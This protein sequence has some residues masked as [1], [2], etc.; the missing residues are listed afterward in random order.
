M[1]SISNAPGFDRT[2]SNACVPIDPVDP[3]M[4][5]CLATMGK[6]MAERYN[7]RYSNKV[8]FYTFAS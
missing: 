4:L 5:M 3:S 6:L 2:T 8:L 7:K 1:Q